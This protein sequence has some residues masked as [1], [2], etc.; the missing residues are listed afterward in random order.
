MQHG[1]PTEDRVFGLPRTLPPNS[2]VNRVSRSYDLLSVPVRGAD[3]AYA[4]EGRVA[5]PP[6]VFLHGWGASHKYFRSCYSAFSPRRRCI[7][8]DLPGFGVS[9]KAVKT[10]SV[11]AYADW[12]GG[13]LD[14]MKLD[15]VELVGHSMGGTIALLFALAHPERVSKLV[16]VNPVVYGPSALSARHRLMLHPLL[17]RAVFTLLKFRA[18]RQRVCTDFTCA[19]PLDDELAREIAA[20]DYR[21]CLSSI[22]SMRTIDLRERLKGLAVPALSIASELDSVVDPLQPAMV[23]TAQQRVFPGIGHIPMVE[24]PVDFNRAVAAFLDG[25]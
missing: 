2:P 4:Q 15:R 19:G 13:F 16:V 9:S 5:L 1:A 23:T 7:A 21:T 8:P 11:E 10:G 17:R 25:A 6:L 12:L 14:A 20:A 18:V 24:C 3:V 22:Q